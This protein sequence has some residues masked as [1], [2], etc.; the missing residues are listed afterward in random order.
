MRI[1]G[2]DGGT[3]EVR[4]NVCP[5][6][7]LPDLVT[8][9]KKRI[10]SA[11]SR[12][13]IEKSRSAWSSCS[14]DRFFRLVSSRAC[15]IDNGDSDCWPRTSNCVTNLIGYHLLVLVHVV[16]YGVGRLSGF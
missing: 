5:R 3:H 6:F 15:G 2:V 7:W 1:Q 16:P 10:I 13:G 8:R 11:K 14:Q 9:C 4:F 12:L